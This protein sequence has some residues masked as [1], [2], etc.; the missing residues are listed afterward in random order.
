M[1]NFLDMRGVANGGFF[2]ESKRRNEKEVSSKARRKKR[3]GNIKNWGASFQ[4]SQTQKRNATKTSDVYLIE[5]GR[6]ENCMA[7]G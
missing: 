4:L 2:W 6:R 3:G 7:K 1:N 5:G